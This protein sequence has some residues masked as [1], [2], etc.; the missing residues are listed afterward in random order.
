M[1]RF[2]RR[3]LWTIVVIVP[4]WHLEPLSILLAAAKKSS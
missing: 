1:F 3:T 2:R 4:V